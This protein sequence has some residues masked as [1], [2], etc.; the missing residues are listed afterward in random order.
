M[1]AHFG[2]RL[3]HRIDVVPRFDEGLAY[4]IHSFFQG[5][6]Q[7]LSVALG[8]G[9]EAQGDSRKVHPLVR[10]QLSPHEDNGFDLGPERRSRLAAE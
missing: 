9:A 3:P 7:A 8:E 2:R 5:E 1:L 4:G 10:A 6:F